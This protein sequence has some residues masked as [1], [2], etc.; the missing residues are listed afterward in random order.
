MSLPAKKPWEM[1]ELQEMLLRMG[2]IVIIRDDNVLCP[3]CTE[4]T[5]LRVRCPAA[6]SSAAIGSL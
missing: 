4:L 2:Y 3:Q 1:V 5:L 6:S